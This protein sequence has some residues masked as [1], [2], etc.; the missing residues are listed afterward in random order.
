MLRRSFGSSVA[1]SLWTGDIVAQAYRRWSRQR[2]DSLYRSRLEHLGYY[3]CDED[4]TF[5]KWKD[6]IL[7]DENK[8]APSITGRRVD[9]VLEI[10]ARTFPWCHISI[11]IRRSLS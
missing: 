8:R 5:D 10:Q 11:M 2:R 4:G 7:E 9:K 1:L 3:P 6:I